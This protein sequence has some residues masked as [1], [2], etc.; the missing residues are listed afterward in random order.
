MDVVQGASS[1]GEIASVLVRY[2]RS[3]YVFIIAEDIFAVRQRLITPAL[4]RSPFY[5]G[6]LPADLTGLSSGDRRRF[7]ADLNGSEVINR[8]GRG[9]Y[10]TAM[11][12]AMSFF[13]KIFSHKQ[14]LIYLLT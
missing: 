12:R 9:I 6:R 2:W 1:D 14:P 4:R 11:R 7:P 10:G 8:H 13:V 3:R 5:S